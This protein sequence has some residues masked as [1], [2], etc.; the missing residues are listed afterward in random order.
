VSLWQCDRL[1]PCLSFH[2]CSVYM[3]LYRDNR[4]KPRNLPSSNAFFRKS[5]S[6]RHGLTWIAAVE[7]AERR[8]LLLRSCTFF[9]ANPEGRVAVDLSF[10]RSLVPRISSGFPLRKCLCYQPSGAEQCER[11]VHARARAHTHTQTHTHTHTHT[12][13]SFACNMKRI[14]KVQLNIESC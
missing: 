14:V 9:Y 5:G 3:V 1:L 7:S 10:V 2:R 12:E 8:L 6:V 13:N 4:A 11:P